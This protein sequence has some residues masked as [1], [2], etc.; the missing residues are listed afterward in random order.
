MCNFKRSVG[1]WRQLGH[2][3]FVAW[4]VKSQWPTLPF[5]RPC[6]TLVVL[7]RTS[8]ESHPGDLGGFFFQNFPLGHC[9]LLSKESPNI[10]FKIK[11]IVPL[12]QS[13]SYLSGSPDVM[14]ADCLPPH[15]R[16]SLLHALHLLIH[17]VDV[18]LCVQKMSGIPATKFLSGKKFLSKK[19]TC[20]SRCSETP[21]LYWS[22][23]RVCECQH[24]TK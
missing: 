19:W 18:Y 6:K 7:G 4:N 5:H 8:N 16:Q 24:S 23:I 9:A 14:I 12:K 21:T 20:C 17:C 22:S 2:L 13:A 1:H 10:C 11:I 15:N 3:A